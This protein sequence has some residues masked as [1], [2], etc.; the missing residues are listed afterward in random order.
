MFDG[1]L[2]VSLEIPWI[3]ADSFGIPSTYIDPCLEAQRT[4]QTSSISSIQCEAP[5]I[6]KLV[7]KWLNSMVY[8][9]YNYS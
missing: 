8:G 6:A 7:Y 5:K 2:R 9:R 3:F 1:F 4:L